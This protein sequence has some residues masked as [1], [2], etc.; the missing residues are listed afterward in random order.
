[1]RVNACGNK[2]WDFSKGAPVREALIQ[3][4]SLLAAPCGWLATSGTSPL[5]VGSRNRDWLV[6]SGTFF[7]ERRGEIID[8]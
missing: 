5:G 3:A 1:M 7:E 2:Y 8:I 6:T 4:E